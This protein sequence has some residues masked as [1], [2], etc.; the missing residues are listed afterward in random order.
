M[1]YVGT[2]ISKVRDRT[3]NRKFTRTATTGVFTS[4]LNHNLFLEFLNDAQDYLQS[5]VVS[6]FAEEFVAE[7]EI[8]VVANQEAYSIPD[9]VF[10]GRKLVQVDYSPDGTTKNYCRLPQR[11]ILAR[12]T[13]SVT[14]PSFYIARNSQILLNPI[15]RTTRGK[16]RVSYYRELDRLDIRRGKIS[17]TPTTTTIVLDADD[18]L[19]ETAINEAQYLCIVDKFGVVQDYA[20][21]IESYDSGTRTITIPTTTLTG[22]A[23]DYV[24]MGQY[25]TSHSDL[26][27]NAERYL[28]TYCQL[29]IL[30]KDASASEIQEMQ[31]LKDMEKDIVNAYAEMSQDVTEIPVLDHNLAG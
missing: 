22:D 26:A 18:D 13:S 4:G 8:S 11:S 17:S 15:P 1:R 9:N 16:I 3:D 31:V 28:K 24:V 25:A 27:E 7:K 6:N 19:D 12:N 5:R 2:I 21:E 10:L 30:H 14:H 29:R 20:V 23:G